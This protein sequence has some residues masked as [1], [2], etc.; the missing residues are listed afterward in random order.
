MNT[1]Q[2][3][4]RYKDIKSKTVDALARGNK[5]IDKWGYEGVVVDV[6]E[7]CT[8]VWQSDRTNYGCDNCEHYH[9]TD[10]RHFLKVLSL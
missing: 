4:Q 5:V 8:T 3:K 9:T 6:N 1:K 10:W 2:R 7:H